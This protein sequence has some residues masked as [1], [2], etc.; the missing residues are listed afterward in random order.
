MKSKS[1]LITGLCLATLA[2]SAAPNASAKDKKTTKEA[3]ASASPTEGASPAMH[4]TRYYGKIASVDSSAKTFTIT[5]KK[6]K[7]RVFTMTDTTEITKDGQPATMADV[8]AD[9]DVRGQYYKQ[10]D[11][12][13]EAKSVMLG[14]KSKHKG[15]HGH[16][17]MGMEEASPEPTATP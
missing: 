7:S 2:L 9:Q 16:K 12:K 6:G 4:G 5:S 1:L 15:H 8:T 3:T 13:M 10:A 14:M 17:K 11:G